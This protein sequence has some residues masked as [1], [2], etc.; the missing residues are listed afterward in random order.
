ML[1]L[2]LICERLTEVPDIYEWPQIGLMSSP[3]NWSQF[4]YGNKGTNPIQ[5]I[6][7]FCRAPPWPRA[8]RCDG[9]GRWCRWCRHRCRCSC[10]CYRWVVVDVVVVVVVIVA[11]DAFQDK[12]KTIFEKQSETPSNRKLLAETSMG[13]FDSKFGSIQF[14]FIVSI[15]I[16]GIFCCDDLNQ[17]GVVITLVVVVAVL[18]S[19]VAAV[20]VVAVLVSVVVAVIAVVA[21][22]VVEV[23]VTR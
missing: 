8:M 6:W 20:D 15:R 17:P 4:F 13:F 21:A 23:V 2:K 16:L 18:A 3:D 1:A 10:C 9:G 12:T 11:E 22:A 5:K 14:W 19:A 7:K